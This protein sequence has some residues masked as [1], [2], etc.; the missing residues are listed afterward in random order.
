MF[1]LINSNLPSYTDGLPTFYSVSDLDSI[2]NLKDNDV[3]EQLP[4]SIHSQ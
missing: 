4:T 1:N 3:D 2:P